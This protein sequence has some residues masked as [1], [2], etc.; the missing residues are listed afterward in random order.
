M[1]ARRCD[2]FILR[3]LFLVAVV[4]VDGA[5]NQEREMFRSIVGISTDNDD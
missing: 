2:T 4:C 3:L 1:V 5:S